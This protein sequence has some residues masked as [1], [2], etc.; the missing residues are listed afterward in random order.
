MNAIGYARCS[1]HEQADSGLGMKAQ[2]ECIRAYCSL[3]E[4][5]LVDIISDEGVSGSKPLARRHG[6]QQLLEAVGRKAASAIVMLKL[7]RM[8]RNAHDCLG[9][10]EEWDRQGVALHVVERKRQPDRCLLHRQSHRQLQL[11]ATPS[12]LLQVAS[13]L[14]PRGERD[15]ALAHGTGDRIGA[16]SRRGLRQG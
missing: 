2:A 7:D 3:K 14:R 16:G 5:A 10:V 4:L 13:A 8:F 12:G 6:G 9:T 1:T 11:R 15:H